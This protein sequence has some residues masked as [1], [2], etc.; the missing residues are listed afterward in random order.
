[1]P[2]AF[3]VLMKTGLKSVRNNFLIS[4]DV[5][6]FPWG[7]F[8]DCIHILS[9]LLPLNIPC[10]Y[11]YCS[12]IRVP[13][14]KARRNILCLSLSLSPLLRGLCILHRCFRLNI[15]INKSSYKNKCFSPHM[16]QNVSSAN[17]V[18]SNPSFMHW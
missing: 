5:L 2:H 4:C 16:S 9:R 6:Y 17:C 13:I 10:L 1:M 8:F 18:F 14:F 11:D 15:E 3:L 12:Y 7:N